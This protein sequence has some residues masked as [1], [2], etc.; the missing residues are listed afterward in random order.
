[1][2]NQPPHEYHSEYGENFQQTAPAA[3]N[4]NY[5]PQDPYRPSDPYVQPSASQGYPSDN[6]Y[7]QPASY[8][9]QQYQMPQNPSYAPPVYNIPTPEQGRGMAIAG[10][11]MGIL[12]IFSAFIPFVGLIFPILGIIFSILGRRSVSLRVA[13]TIGLILSI[14]GIVLS[15]VM[16]F[17]YYQIGTH[18]NA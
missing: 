17:V 7:T 5:Q 3:Y 15:F 18:S 8:Q 12:S 11:I 16:L 4:S 6:P 1:M 14:I 10:L 13:A 2:S 9:Q